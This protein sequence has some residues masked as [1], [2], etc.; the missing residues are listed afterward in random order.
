MGQYA[1]AQTNHG[2][3]SGSLKHMKACH[4]VGILPILGVEGYF[5]PKRAGLDK[6]WRY[7]KWH[8]VLLAK[9][10]KGWHNLIKITS[11]SFASGFYQYPCFDFE[12]ME[13]YSEGL[14]ASTSCI[15]GPL[16]FLIENGTDK[17]ADEFIVR[18]Q[19]IYGNDLYFS[20]MPHD[21]DRQR[22]VNLQIISLANKFG[23]PIVYEGDS[24][25]PYKGWVDTQKIAI[26]IGT[27]STV[28]E[29]EKKNK[30]RIAKGEEIYELWHDGLHLMD[31]TEVKD[32]FATAHPDISSIIVDECIAN[33]DKVAGKIEPFLMDRSI[34][35]PKAGKSPKDAESKVIQW[36]QEGLERVSKRNDEN[37]ERR[38]E[39]ELEVIRNRSNFDYF[40]IT[41]DWVRWSKSSDPLPGQ[42]AGKKPMR[43]GSGRGSV[44]A[45]LVSFLCGITTLDPIAH[46]FKFERFL[47]PERKG[48][49]D[50][51]VDFPSSRRNE[52][53]EYLALKYGRDCIADVVAH[54]HFQP[55]A[56]LKSVTKVLYGF[57][58]EAYN[59]IAKICHEDSGLID[60]VHDSDLE[61]MRLRIPELDSWGNK[62]PYA[63]EQ[64]VRL[65]NAS[66]PFVMRL[67]R[68]A[69]GVVITPGP[70]TDYMPTLRSDEK[71][72]GFRT[73]W[74]ETPRISI[75]D[76]FGFVKWDALGL[77]GMDQQQMILNLIE[78]RTGNKIDLD[79]LACL[80]DPY[81]VETD[82]ME[83]FQKGLTLGVNQFSGNGVTHFMKKAKPE[84]CIDLA[85][86][87]ALYRPGPMG[88]QGHIHYARRKSGAEEFSVSEIL[89]PVLADTHYTISFQEQVMGL[90]ETLADYSAGESDGI[91]KIIAKLYREKGPVAQKELE[92]H[93]KIFLEKAT[94][95]IGI[96]EAQRIWE[97]ILPYTDYSFN[98]AHAGGYGIQA[99]QDQW[100][101]V[102]YPLE[103]YAVVMTL[104]P[105]TSL[106][107][108]KEAKN[109]GIDI[110]PP[111]V[112]VSNS[113]YT[114]DFDN[115][116]L[117]YGLKGIK[118]MADISAEQVMELRPFSSLGDFK[119]RNKFKYSKVNKKHK[120]I[121]IEVG[122]LDSLGGRDSWTDTEKAQA[123]M[124]LLGMSLSAGG[125]L[126][127]DEKYII[128]KTHSEEEYLELEEGDNVVIAGAISEIKKTEVKKGKQVGAKMGFAKIALGLD[129]FSCT[130][131]PPAWSANKNL[132]FIG[133]KIIVNGRKDSR[134]IIVQAAMSIE[135]YL[136]ETKVV[137]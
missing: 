13:K 38:L 71:E 56:A 99:Y 57:D 110:L 35:M 4:Q 100:L 132:L 53:K 29:A 77:T 18:L 24:H 93:E 54:Q 10:L 120:E 97:E 26:L 85:A 37:Y 23:A 127:D 8:F 94:E 22:A 44:A 25:Y 89:E 126:G 66:E 19:K 123:E 74:S 92:K 122:A 91:R 60:Q 1:L 41:G 21:F 115:N 128:E 3:L 95:K 131:F 72:V 113:S 87:N 103:F 136:N 116:A 70:I 15:L 36:C 130:F 9:N 137:L 101:K 135:D 98:R 62:F 117:R 47:N 11:E 52:A 67:S 50:I 27:N 114:A 17:E 46:K 121:L 86:I 69:G 78:D 12:L 33:T 129:S 88:K 119:L 124:Q 64:A 133:S 104:E 5:R 39:Y 45:S 109:F 96:D 16:P 111:D 63:F 90:F 118:G 42:T 61:K 73:A 28:E 43:I 49:P 106:R 58:S 30:E 55:R 48:L 2:V 102:H 81:A 51:D 108:I 6:S 40:F 31:E 76:D 14:I 82:V 7:R 34:K 84:N 107:A 79:K 65:E 32:A 20:I 83:A 68:H 80:S 125:T 112:N 105:K 134:G 75:V 59:V